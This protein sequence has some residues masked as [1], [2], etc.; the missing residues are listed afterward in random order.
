MI[1][2]QVDPLDAR[3]VSAAIQDRDALESLATDLAAPAS[4][5][6]F[7]LDRGFAG[8]GLSAFFQQ[9]TYSL[10]TRTNPAPP[11]GH[12]GAA[13]R[14]VPVP[15]LSGLSRPPQARTAPNPSAKVRANPTR[16]AVIGRSATAEGR[17]VKLTV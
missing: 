14:G 15:S 1:D 9:Q 12:G 5:L 7:G 16:A 4:L 13:A 2:T 3:V 8:D 17:S 11:L 10:L 6:L